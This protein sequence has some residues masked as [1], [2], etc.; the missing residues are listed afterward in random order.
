[1][2]EDYPRTWLELEQRFHDE[3]DCL[4]YLQALRW[5][6]GLRCPRCHS[7]R[8][9]PMKNGLWLCQDCRHQNSVLAGTVFQD[10]KLPLATWFTAMWHVTS[11]KNGVSA[12]GLQ[13]ALLLHAL[14]QNKE[15]SP[16][17]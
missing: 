8:A 10:T 6:E 5:P 11:Q 15:Q 3:T 1:M 4:A 14:I 7:Q 12:L 9:W 16:F 13:R 2:N 17:A